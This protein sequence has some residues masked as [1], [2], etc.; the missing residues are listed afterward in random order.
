MRYTSRII[1]QMGMLCEFQSVGPLGNFP[2]F[3]GAAGRSP[4]RAVGWGFVASSLDFCHSSQSHSSL[5]GTEW[6]DFGD[7]KG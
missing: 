2:F 6:T 5:L 1:T 4:I 7:E 3:Q